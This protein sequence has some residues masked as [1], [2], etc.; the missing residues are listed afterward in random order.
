MLLLMFRGT[1]G[2][3]VPPAV[4]GSSAGR[5]NQQ[6]QTRQAAVGRLRRS[7]VQTSKR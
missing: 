4:V 7:N 3:Y 2:P 5:V 6:K 1:S